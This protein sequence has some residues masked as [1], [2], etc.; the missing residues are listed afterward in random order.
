MYSTTK[1]IS[2]WIK[3]KTKPENKNYV[4]DVQ[5]CKKVNTLEGGNKDRLCVYG[6]NSGMHLCV[7]PQRPTQCTLQCTWLMYMGR[8]K[9]LSAFECLHSWTIVSHYFSG[10]TTVSGWLIPA[11]FF[12]P[13]VWKHRGRGV[14]G[15]SLRP[16]LAFLPEWPRGLHPST[17]RGLPACLQT[18]W[19]IQ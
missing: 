4:S 16:G 15:R 10:R 8:W 3:N 19:Q 5:L 2:L 11:C 6:L 18:T 17:H 1:F 13:G 12:A 14:P 9:C 7:P